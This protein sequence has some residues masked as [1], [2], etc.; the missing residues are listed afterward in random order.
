VQPVHHSQPSAYRRQALNQNQVSTCLICCSQCTKQLL[1]HYL[2]LLPAAQHILQHLYIAAASYPTTI[3]AASTASA[4]AASSH[5]SRL[6]IMQ[7]L[8][9]LKSLLLL[10]MP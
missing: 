5:S 2:W 8:L 7:Q 6:N 9:L 4:A 3:A 10:L 1:C